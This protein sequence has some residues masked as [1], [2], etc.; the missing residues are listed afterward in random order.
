M[1]RDQVAAF[2]DLSIA[3]SKRLAVGRGGAAVLIDDA[4]LTVA[5]QQYP[6]RAYVIPDGRTVCIVEDVPGG[7]SLMNASERIM[8]AVRA[9]YPD[10][11]VV[12]HWPKDPD[13]AP[14]R[15]SDGEGGS[16]PIDIG[17]YGISDT[18]PA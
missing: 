18:A 9:R 1:G 13:F 5:N 7:T 10:A 8:R 11:I 2:L 4:P 14:Y 17:D 15:L 3:L 12:E 16:S 6:L